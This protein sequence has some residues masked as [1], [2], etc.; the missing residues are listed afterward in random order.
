MKLLL[1][2]NVGCGKS[3]ISRE[4]ISSG[5][6]F[7]LLNID[8]F[9]RK[10]GDGSME[11]EKLAKERFV[12]EIDIDN[13]NQIIECSGL[14]DTGEMVFEKLLKCKDRILVFVLLADSSICIHRLLNRIWDIPYPDK[15][16]NVNKLIEKQALI[17][18]TNA[19]EN[20]WSVLSNII[21][22]SSINNSNDD[23]KK[24]FQI[25]TNFIDETERNN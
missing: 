3:T 22:K 8:D 20:K 15:T 6:Q 18:K 17:Y 5:K 25:I 21:F 19:I 14:G 2:G 24:N 12:D 11:K 4:I 9:R 7:Q 13:S 23:F 16:A 10:F 1:F